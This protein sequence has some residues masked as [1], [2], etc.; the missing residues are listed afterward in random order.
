MPFELK[1]SICLYQ[2]I[3]IYMNYSNSK[4]MSRNLPTRKDLQLIRCH[5]CC[6]SLPSQLIDQYGKIKSI[7]QIDNF[8]SVFLRLNF[9][10]K[11]Y[12]FIA[13]LFLHNFNQTCRYQKPELVYNLHAAHSCLRHIFEYIQQ[14]AKSSNM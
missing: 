8:V 4:F 12:K 14:S 6:V 1:T 9:R 2:K 13:F 7:E 5:T 11:S 10:Y 3:N